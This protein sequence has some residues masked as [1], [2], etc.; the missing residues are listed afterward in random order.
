[1]GSS[2]NLFHVGGVFISIDGIIRLQAE[3]LPRYEHVWIHVGVCMIVML[4][5]PR[6]HAP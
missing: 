4:R 5:R 3:L 1:M 6:F 2:K